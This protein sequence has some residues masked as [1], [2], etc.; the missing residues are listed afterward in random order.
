MAPAALAAPT[1]TRAELNNGS[2]RV[3]GRGAVPAG[4]VTIASTK[5][6]ESTITRSADSSGNFRIEASAFTASECRVTVSDAT[7][8]TYRS[9]FPN[10]SGAVTGTER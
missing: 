7:G 1:V 9:P 6:G 3:E 4:A 10:D 2:L 8:S 5:A